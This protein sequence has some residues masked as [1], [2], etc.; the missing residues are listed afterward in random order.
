M[1]RP[2]TLYILPVSGEDFISQTSFLA[3]LMGLQRPRPDI[4]LAASGGAIAAMISLA[5][6]WK[7]A[8]VKRI[9]SKMSSRLFS[10]MW[11]LN[12]AIPGSLGAVLSGFIHNSLYNTAPVSFIEDFLKETFS[13]SCLDD[14]EIWISTMN[15]SKGKAELFCS[16]SE[17]ASILGHQ[18]CNDMFMNNCLP[19]KFIDKDISYLSKVVKASASIPVVFQ[20]VKIDGD[21]HIDSADTFS[22]PFIPLQRDISGIQGPLHIIYFAC[23]DYERFETLPNDLSLLRDGSS[24]LANLLRSLAMVSRKNAI[25][26]VLRGRKF[27]FKEGPFD[28]KSARLLF[29][30]IDQSQGSF[31]E[32]YN[33]TSSHINVAFFRP[34][35]VIDAFMQGKKTMF[36]RLWIVR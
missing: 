15:R 16:L 13:P 34:Q 22:D 27:C 32:L 1:E 23:R 25:E 11:P 20:P 17:Q 19:P 14:I 28:R 10:R 12:V 9:L 2:T 31:L 21:L 7:E 33:T 35:E 26:T 5:A 36:F 6:H 18:C 3:E 29:E 8:G 24:A 4:I 30:E